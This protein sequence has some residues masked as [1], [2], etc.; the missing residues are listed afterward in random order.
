LSDDLLQRID[1]TVFDNPFTNQHR[2]HYYDHSGNKDDE[3][4]DPNID[5]DVDN[6]VDN[7]ITPLVLEF[8]DVFGSPFA[9][10]YDWALSHRRFTWGSDLE[11]IKTFNN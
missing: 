4:L 8:K 6:D 11:V 10:S 3:M 7:E 9:I 2:F 5:D 1:D